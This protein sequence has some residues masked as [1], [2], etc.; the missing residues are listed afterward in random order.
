MS[1]PKFVPVLD[2][3][4]AYASPPVA[5]EPWTNDRP[6]DIEGFQPAGERLGYQGPD[7]GYGLM[8]ARRMAPKVHVVGRIDL[9]DAV[10]GALNIALRRASLYGRAPVIHDVALAFTIWG[11]FD[12]DPP[13]DLVAARDD[14][15][16]GIGNVHHYAEGRAVADAVPESTLRLTPKQAAERYRADWRTLCGV[17]A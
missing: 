4:R 11:F 3:V 8:L 14:M 2:D 12:A 10:R 9:E 7:Q 6:G 17:M 13:A 1:A 15:F 5:P 16:M